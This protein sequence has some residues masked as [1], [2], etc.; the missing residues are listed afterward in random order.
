MD[1]ARLSNYPLSYLPRDLTSGL[2]VF[3]VALPLCLG[4]ALASGAPL[5]SGL[6]AG[7]IGGIVVGSISG[8]STSVSGPAAGLTAIVI[9]QIASLGSFEAFLLA[10][11]IG[12]VIQ[13][14]LGIVRAGSLSSFFPSSVIKGLLAAIGVILILKQIPHL[15]GHDTDPEGEMSFTQPDKQNT[16]SEIMTLFEGDIHFGA[17]AVGVMSIVLLLAWGRVK[18]L[19]NSVIPGPLVVVLLGVSLHLLFQRLGGPLAIEASHMVQIPVA[20]SANDL[21]T[22]LKFPDFSQ[23]ANPAIYLAGV[24]IAIVASLETLLNLEAV[25]KLD[26]ENRNSP[27]SREL[28]AQGVGNMV[29]G[30]VGGL[31]VTSVIVRGSVNVNAGAKTKVSCIFHGVL[32]LICVGLFPVYLN[33]IPLSALAA[34]LFVT[35]FKLASPALF[36][37]MWK[38]GRYQF[39]P[40][41]ITLLSIVFTDLLTGILIGL[42]VSVLFILNSS[43]RQP[44]RRI[45]ETHLGGDILHIELANQVSFLN[46]AALD[47]LFNEAESGTNMLIDASDTD[48]I[49]PDILSLIQEFK[50]QI[51][52]ARGVK[53]SLRGFRKK[54]QLNDEIQFADFSTRELQDRVTAEQVLEILREGNR[55]FYTGNRLSRDLGH[56][57]NATA[58]EQNPLAVVLSC[59]DSRVPAELVLDL[60]I[61][62]VLSVRVAGNVIGNKSLGSIEYGV[63][64]AGVKLVLVL[65]HTR[66]GAIQSTVQLLGRSNQIEQI[67]A[68]PHLDSIISEV[69]HCVDQEVCKTLHE[70]SLEEQEAFMD[71]VARKN[72]L[73]SV[74]EIVERSEVIQ[75]LIEADQVMVVGALYDVKSGKM[76][77]FT[78]QSAEQE[79]EDS[80]QV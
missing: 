33:L 27:P 43:L 58:G 48:Y 2:V 29:S 22:F 49:D 70:M 40:F 46:R 11:M 25:D 52:P 77:F 53:V 80:P 79:A 42:G 39:A 45:V 41:L 56:Q 12:G 54:Y 21:L 75:K 6:L 60:G 73:R 78:E 37:Q 30:L 32:L 15:L 16:F 62:D 51:G 76:D 8:S 35:G 69:E 74:H 1:D 66:C 17:A 24:T 4:I 68:C 59:I 7:I 36:R 61:G 34:I 18:L 3:L 57:V 28:V 31:P 19:K 14:G 13:I 23:W 5:F 50:N 47:Q 72:V 64:V 65:G 71:E 55:R 44:I 20:E 67:A 9:A 38:E 10:V 26:P 63:A